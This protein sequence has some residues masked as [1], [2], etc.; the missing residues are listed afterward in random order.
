MLY[1]PKIITSSADIKYPDAIFDLGY[2]D[3]IYVD[4]I[5]KHKIS[6]E[7]F[8]IDITLKFFEC[9]FNII[10]DTVGFIPT[11]L[12]IIYKKN[13]KT[14]FE[15][16]D[17]NENK[18][19]TILSNECIYTKL[20]IEILYEVKLIHNPKFLYYVCDSKL[21]YDDILLNGIIP[22]GGRIH[23]LSSLSKNQIGKYIFIIKSNYNLYNA[24]YYELN[25]GVYIKDYI[26]SELLV[27]LYLDKDYEKTLKIKL[28]SIKIKNIINI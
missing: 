11:K 6:L 9:I 16:F 7:F 3:Y 23:L 24:D 19:E 13:N 8:N 17:Y 4:E 14:F 27:P 5:N 2:S 12:E 1:Q 18:L 21:N 26:E 25:N 15:K 10:N 20:I 22:T 28:R